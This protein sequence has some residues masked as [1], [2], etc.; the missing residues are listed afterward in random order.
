MFDKSDYENMSRAITLARHGLY[1][2]HPNPR[3]GCVIVNNG[4]VVGEGFHAYAGGPHA[5]IV[6][7]KQAGEHARGAT[8]YVTLEPCCHHGKTPPCSDAL[9][10]AGVAKVVAAMLDPNPRV[11]GQGMR[12][13]T[14]AGVVCEVDLLS[15]QAQA[16]NPGF[17]KR[18]TQRMPYVRSKMAM[19]LDGKTAMASGESQ[20][21][22][23]EAARTEVQHWRAQSSAI[24][25]GI[26]TVLA[27]D[28]RLTVRDQALLQ[29]GAKQPLRVLVDSALR[30][31][32]NAALLQ[33]D[34]PVLIVTANDST[35]T[36]QKKNVEVLSMPGAQ[37]NVDL[38]RLMQVLAER[39]INEVLVEAGATLNGALL[40]QHLIDE[41]IVY[42]APVLMG[43][44]AMSLVNLPG[45]DKM[46]DKLALSI[47]DVRAI[48]QDW[49]ITAAVKKT[50]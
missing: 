36:I 23:G 9:I 28:A 42:I 2:T 1:S 4:R 47:T 32:D 17:I 35:R 24:L 20:W 11:S 7:L 43:N 22:T 39:E 27:D 8:A 31:S 48:G 26:N 49:R 14:N 38:T 50:H 33:T 3:V 18:M 21:I 12:A 5:E 44:Q 37:G 15:Q 45:L 29:Q 46:Q 30:V 41:L 6:A 40:Q 10:A 16:L 13:L 19:S 25:T 34:G